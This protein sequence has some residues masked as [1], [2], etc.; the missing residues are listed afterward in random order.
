MEKPICEYWNSWNGFSGKIIASSAN[1]I[2][3]I[4]NVV[5]RFTFMALA[6]NMNFKT[7][8]QKYRFILTSVFIALFF[9]TGL[10][11][12]LAFSDLRLDNS[13]LSNLFRGLYTDFNADWFNDAGIF[14]L[15]TYKVQMLF[16]IVEFC[17][18]ASIRT[19]KRCCDQKK[20]WPNDFS[21]TNAPTIS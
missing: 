18:R 2:I 10:L 6:R 9:Q 19:L 15:T 8:S 1:Y 16:P 3:V 4:M 17:L 12:L 11:V 21:R 5:M 13:F 20:I 7:K 14:L